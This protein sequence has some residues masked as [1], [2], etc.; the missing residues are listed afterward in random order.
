[1]DFCSICKNSSRYVLNMVV[2]FYMDSSIKSF[3]KAMKKIVLI[4]IILQAILFKSGIP[5]GTWRKKE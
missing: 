2:L 1:M 4:K 5:R 3:L